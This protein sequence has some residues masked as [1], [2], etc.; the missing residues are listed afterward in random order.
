MMFSSA[1]L[2]YTF[3]TAEES[4][5][6][7]SNSRSGNGGKKRHN[8]KN[9][10]E[11]IR[12]LRKRDGITQEKLAESLGVSFQSVSRWENGLAW[13]DVTLIPFLARYFRVSADTLFDMEDWGTAEREKYYDMTYIQYRRDGKLAL[14]KELMEQAVREFP[15]KHHY[16][17]NLAE[18]LEAYADGTRVQREEY[19]EG[20]FSGRIRRLCQR[21]LEESRDSRERCRSVRLLCSSYVSAG[22]FA[23]GTGGLG[24]GTLPGGAAGADSFWRGKAAPATGKYTESR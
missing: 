7:N 16:I 15:H 4:Y 23:P 5:R 2:V 12:E 1:V 20:E 10:G 18:D 19:A 17:M 13:P 8:M 24:Y 14:R 22:G 21:V 9:I 6:G 11:I 3:S